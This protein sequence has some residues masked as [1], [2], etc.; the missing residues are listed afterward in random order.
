MNKANRLPNAS[1]LFSDP[2]LEK[3]DLMTESNQ[4]NEIF[5][6]GNSINVLH[7]KN[8]GNLYANCYDKYGEP[9]IVVGSNKLSLVIIYEILLHSSF[10]FLFFYVFEGLFKILKIINS[11]VYFL[12]FFNHF[13]L[14]LLNPGLVKRSRCSQEFKKTDVYKS[15][16][17]IEKKKLSIL[18]NL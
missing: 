9:L 1:Y 6:F 15:L 14:F 18:R 11:I 5:V 13:S 12:L 17:R 10:L 7:P 4:K 8:I 16:S 3:N 2:R